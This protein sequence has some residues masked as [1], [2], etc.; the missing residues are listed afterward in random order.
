MLMSEQ[1]K[2]WV[3]LRS[4]GAITCGAVALKSMGVRQIAFQI[5]SLQVC[6]HELLS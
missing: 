3:T 1:W 5:Q 6:N 2:V 4:A